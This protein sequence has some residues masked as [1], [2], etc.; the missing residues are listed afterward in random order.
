MSA[1]KGSFEQLTIRYSGT[2]SCEL[3][4][5]LINKENKICSKMGNKVADTLDRIKNM[6]LGGKKPDPD[7]TKN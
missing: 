5:K 7:T 4:E 6:P 3:K 2:R 1:S